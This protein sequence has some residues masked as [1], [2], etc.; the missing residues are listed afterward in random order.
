MPCIEHN[1]AMLLSVFAINLVWSDTQVLI[2]L[3]T[4]NIK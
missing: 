4:S 1:R 2:C 3:K